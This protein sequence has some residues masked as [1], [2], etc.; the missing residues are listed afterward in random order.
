MVYN[1][2]IPNKQKYFKEVATMTTAEH[3]KL[4]KEYYNG[5]KKLKQVSFEMAKE[6]D[7][8][9]EKMGEYLKQ[10]EDKKYFDDEAGF[11]IKYVQPQKA[12]FDIDKLEKNIP[13]YV[14][15]EVIKKRLVVDNE[16]L[17]V[18]LLNRCNFP[19][20]EFWQCVTVEKEVDTK[21][22][23]QML[24]LGEVDKGMLDGTFEIVS[25]K[26][27]LKVTDKKD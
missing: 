18:A 22:L 6:L 26:P 24:D 19:M 13:V 7:K 1:N 8:K 10:R 20:D 16:I 25:K 11:A 4:A 15:R 12:I 2:I 9:G 21:A 17:F 14:S 23:E 5:Y 27:Y 3:E